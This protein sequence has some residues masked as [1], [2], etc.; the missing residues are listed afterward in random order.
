MRIDSLQKDATCV[1]CGKVYYFELDTRRKV[2]QIVK[3][4]STSKE[5]LADQ[6]VRL[7]FSQTQSLLTDYSNGM[8]RADIQIKY[9]ISYKAYKYQI[10]KYNQDI[11]D[12]M[13]R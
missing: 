11:M 5:N 1:K 9:N 13:L 3:E 8:P 10:A 4:N 12:G 2:S 7:T 6:Y